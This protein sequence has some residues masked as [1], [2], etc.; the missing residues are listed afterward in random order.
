[1]S[2]Q[3]RLQPL[4]EVDLDEAYV[5]AA[6]HA[7]DTA[8]RWVNRF[9]EALQGLSENPRRFGFAPEHKKLKRELRQMLFGRRP[10]IFRAVYL[11]DGNIVQI[12]RI[13]RASRRRLTRRELGGS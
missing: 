6:R 2:F 9:R 10:N 5:W 12:L 13:R 1:M 4:A 11:I 8:G 3:V 7:P